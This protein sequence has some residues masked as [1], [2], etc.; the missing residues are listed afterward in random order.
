[1]ILTK[2][3]TIGEMIILD[4]NAY[5]VAEVVYFLHLKEHHKHAYNKYNTKLGIKI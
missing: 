2:I 5:R 3:K 4:K 1:M